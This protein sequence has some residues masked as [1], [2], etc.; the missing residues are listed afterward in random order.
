[1]CPALSRS[2]LVIDGNDVLS[3]YRG[4]CI[5]KVGDDITRLR[6]N[7]HDLL[8]KKEKERTCRTC[9]VKNECSRCLYP[10][11]FTD[12]KFCELKRRYPCISTVIPLLQWLYTYAGQ[13]DARVKL[14]IDKNASPLFY[15]GEIKKGTPLPDVRDGIVLGSFNGNAFVFTGEKGFSLD[16][17]KAAILEACILGV[18]RESLISSIDKNS[19][20]IDTTLF[21]FKEL[22]LLT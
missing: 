16:P 1:M 11:S 18:G 15:H 10:Y 12:E 8:L 3:C 20:L 13:T 14:R 2:S 17:V 7:V 6:K 4:G 21:V 22:G 5:G 19:S 9:E